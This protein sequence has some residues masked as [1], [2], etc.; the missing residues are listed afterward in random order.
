MS[1]GYYSVNMHGYANGVIP[2]P[3]IGENGNWF[4]GNEDTEVNA[5]GSQGIPGPEGPQGQKG[6]PGEAGPQGIQGRPGEKGETGPQ[7]LKGDQGEIHAESLIIRPDLW[8]SGT[9]YNFGS[10]LYGQR[11][12]GTITCPANQNHRIS[13]MITEPTT[14]L[15]SCDGW[16]EDGTHQ[17]MI[18]NNYN[19]PTIWS[20]ISITLDPQPTFIYDMLF[21]SRTNSERNNHPYDIRIKYTK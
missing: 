11:F 15:I 13:L 21:I 16:W 5:S 7:G 19:D 17:R 18:G 8:V 9:E 1:K 12:I 14:R 20:G 4:I 3:V 2:V 6:D 10:G